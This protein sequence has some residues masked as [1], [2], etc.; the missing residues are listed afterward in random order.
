MLYPLPGSHR[1]R[2]GPIGGLAVGLPHTARCIAHVAW[3]L[4]RGPIPLGLVDRLL[5]THTARCIAH[6]T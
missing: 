4:R 6:V 3:E 5:H 2:R 1:A